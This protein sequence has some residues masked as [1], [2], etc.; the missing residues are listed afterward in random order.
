M[1]APP[2]TVLAPGD[3]ALFV[4][5][6]RWASDRRSDRAEISLEH[7]MPFGRRLR[8]APRLRVQQRLSGPIDGDT[9]ILS[10]GLMATLFLGRR[11]R[12]E[13]TADH[14][15]V[16]ENLDELTGGELFSESERRSEFYFN[17]RWK[18]TL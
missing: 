10:P 13:V 18:L 7:R 15:W 14:G 6:L 3:L 1:P 5:M 17:A 8:I 2:C 9:T 12:I 11:S 4:A 16:R